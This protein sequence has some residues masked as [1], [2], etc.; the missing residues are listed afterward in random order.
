MHTV[1]T[2]AHMHMCFHFMH[3]CICMYM[4]VE[5]TMKAQAGITEDITHTGTVVPTL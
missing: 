1:H 5:H 4:C 3:M 2:H